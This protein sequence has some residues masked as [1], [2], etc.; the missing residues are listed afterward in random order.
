MSS[1]QR[2]VGRGLI[3]P[4]QFAKMERPTRKLDRHGGAADDL[5]DASQIRNNQPGG[6]RR[7]HID[8]MARPGS[9][10]QVSSAQGGQGSQFGP[11]DAAFGASHLDKSVH[12]RVNPGESKLRARSKR[13]GRSMGP[14]WASTAHV[15]AN[16]SSEWDPQWFQ[17]FGDPESRPE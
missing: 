4:T 5:G 13:Q 3:S 10:G 11:D 14:G 9:Y 1:A 6:V 2:L 17:R 15:R 16:S 7:G 8:A 12:R